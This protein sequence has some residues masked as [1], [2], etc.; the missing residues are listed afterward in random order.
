MMTDNGIPHEASCRC[1]GCDDPRGES[2]PNYC[3]DCGKPLNSAD[4]IAGDRRCGAC[5]GR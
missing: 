1:Y 2:D 3:R 5:E 4:W